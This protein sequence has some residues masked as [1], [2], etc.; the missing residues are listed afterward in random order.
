MDCLRSFQ[1]KHNLEHKMKTFNYFNSS[2]HRISNLSVRNFPKPK[3]VVFKLCSTMCHRGFHKKTGSG[4]G[5]WCTTI[6]RLGRPA[7]STLVLRGRNRGRSST[8]EVVR[9]GSMTLGSSKATTLKA[10]TRMML[11]IQY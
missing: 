4:T 7:P 5:R 8:A 11:R 1:N 3:A 9:K 2:I 6:A 10:S